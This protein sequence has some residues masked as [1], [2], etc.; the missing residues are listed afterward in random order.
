VFISPHVPRSAVI[1]VVGR[2]DY[3]SCGR[4]F[5]SHRGL[6]LLTS[7]KAASESTQL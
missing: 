1:E 5:K 7:K 2:L 6:E 4:E 3:G